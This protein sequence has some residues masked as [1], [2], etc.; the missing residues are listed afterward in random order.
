MSADSARVFSTNSGVGEYKCANPVYDP[1]SRIVSHIMSSPVY[2]EP[3]SNT[4]S[5]IFITYTSSQSMVDHI[6]P[7]RSAF[8]LVSAFAK[9]GAV[10]A[11]HYS[12]ASVVKTAELLLGL[13]PNTIGQAK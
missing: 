13:P 7:H 6:N 11:K 5:A 9:P 2:Y 8:V 10:G 12:S 3:N 1:D 4:G